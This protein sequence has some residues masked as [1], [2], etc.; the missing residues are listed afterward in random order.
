MT[1]LFWLLPHFAVD[2]PRVHEWLVR[3]GYTIQWTTYRGHTT[4]VTVWR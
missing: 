2:I 1:M 4:R 3:H